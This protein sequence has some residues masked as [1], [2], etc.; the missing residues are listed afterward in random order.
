MRC[1]ALQASPSLSDDDANALVILFSNMGAGLPCIICKEH[2]KT[3]IARSPYTI[4]HARDR[5][6]GMQWI[7]DL[8]QAIRDQ[9]EQDNADKEKEVVQEAVPDVPHSTFLVRPMFPELL[10]GYRACHFQEEK[11]REEERLI[12]EAIQN[13]NDN[14]GKRVCPCTLTGKSYTVDNTLLSTAIAPSS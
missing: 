1:I 2:Y 3:N 9:I 14:D 8:R 7:Q 13:S 11:I 4:A 12:L 10:I 6:L 5:K